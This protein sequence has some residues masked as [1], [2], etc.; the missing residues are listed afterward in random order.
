MLLYLSKCI[1][2]SV[3][4]VRMVRDNIRWFSAP[5]SWVLQYM[6]NETDR[7][8]QSLSTW[9]CRTGQPIYCWVSLSHFAMLTIILHFEAISCDLLF[10]SKA[11]KFPHWDHTHRYY[12]TY[13]K[14]SVSAA[15]ENLEFPPFPISILRQPST[16]DSTDSHL[17]SIDPN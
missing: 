3:L 2:F 16:Q 8:D 10:P 13:F 12:G 5:Y 1:E 14:F 4:H 15:A 6:L 9:H 7:P 11:A 17:S